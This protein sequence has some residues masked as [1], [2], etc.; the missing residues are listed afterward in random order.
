MTNPH[1]DPMVNLARDGIPLLTRAHPTLPIRKRAKA[2][3]EARASH[4]W[5][6]N[7]ISRDSL[8]TAMINLNGNDELYTHTAYG[9]RQDANGTSYLGPIYPPG[10]IGHMLS[11]IADQP[12][13]RG[14]YVGICNNCFNPQAKE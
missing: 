9:V 2:M 8:A 1:Y 7:Q 6:R 4:V 5:P 10:T 12:I 14:C 11:D 13:C 3:R